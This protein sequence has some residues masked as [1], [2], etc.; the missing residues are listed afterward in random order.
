MAE[1]PATPL[2]RVEGLSKSFGGVTAVDDVSLTV[3]A[4][5]TVGLV[6]P[7]GAGK[8]TLFGCICGQ[9]MPDR[10]AVYFDGVALAGLPTYK[11]ARLGIGRTYQR[12][13]VF[14]ELYEDERDT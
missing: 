12:I 9:L 6:G 11:R 7:N 3:E 14:P 5:Q 8:T 10:G 1:P 13:E 4:G 2:L